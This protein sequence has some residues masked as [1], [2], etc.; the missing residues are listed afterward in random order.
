[1]QALPERQLEFLQLLKKQPRWITGPLHM[2]GIN[3]LLAYLVTDLGGAVATVHFSLE[4]ENQLTMVAKHVDALAFEERLHEEEQI[5]FHL[6]LIALCEAVTIRVDHF[7]LQA[8]QGECTYSVMEDSTRAELTTKF[9]F[10]KDILGEY[11]LNFAS[12][13]FGAQQLAFLTPGMKVVIEQAYAERQRNVYCYPK[14]VLDFMDYELDLKG[15]F[16]QYTFSR[17][18]M[19]EEIAGYG[20]RIGI[21]FGSTAQFRSFANYRELKSGGVLEEGILKGLMMGIQEVAKREG[22]EIIIGKSLL[23]KR[24]YCIAAVQG[25]GFSFFEQEAP[26]Y[27]LDMPELEEVVSRLVYHEV[28][29]LEDGE[30]VGMVRLFKRQG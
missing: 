10:R 1:M 24:L 30:R 28:L 15:S 12:L 29:E 18:Y 11:E 7:L 3:D 9:K 5:F 20:Y 25:A 2:R 14:G 23:L 26:D 19:E 6:M 16:Y 13:S 22:I 8:F 21:C 27:V 17:Q 4:E